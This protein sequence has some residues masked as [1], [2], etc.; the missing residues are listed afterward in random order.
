MKKILKYT[1]IA[2]CLVTF[3]NSCKSVKG[4]CYDFSKVEFKSDKADKNLLEYC[5]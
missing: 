1:V 4:G 3:L 2:I 5:E